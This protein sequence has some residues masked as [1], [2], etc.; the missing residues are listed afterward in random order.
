VVDRWSQGDFSLIAHD[1]S[2]DELGQLARRLNRMAEQLQHLLRTRQKLATLEERNR[3]A[4]E[5]HD[6]V[7]QQVF[8]VS[9]QVS[10][11]KGL[12]RR[13]AGEALTHLDEAERLVRQAQ[14]ELTALIRE[15]RPAELERQ[16]LEAALREHVTQW[17]RQTGIAADVQSE[18]GRESPPN[19]AETLFRIAQEALTNVARHSQATA[20]QVLMT[21][22][23][24]GAILTIADNGRGF[25]P[26]ATDGQGMG[27]LSMRERAQALGGEVRVESV[28]GQGTTVI[29]RCASTERGA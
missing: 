10:A 18:G 5:L 8:A 27:L 23:R 7:K 17:S 24:D 26:A 29:A 25:D 3:L 6:S 14:R 22:E 16:G 19:V 21:C 11:A 15:L 4:R 20:V 2:D 9:L 1:R 28:A 12:M 13:D